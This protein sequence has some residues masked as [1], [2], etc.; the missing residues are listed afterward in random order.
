VILVDGAPLAGARL[1][2][3]RHETAWVDPAIQLWNRS[4]LENLTYGSEDL[5][6]LGQVIG[7]AELR[8]V[9]AGLPDGMQASL[10]EGGALISGGEGQRVRLG[11]AMLRARPRL[12]I[13]DEPFR[14]LDRE[15]RHALLTRARSLWSG[16]TL[17]CITHDIEETRGFER[18]LVIEGGT[19]VE[20]GSSQT[21]AE[22]EGS[23]YHA[24]LSAEVAVRE[25]IWAGSVWRRIKLEQ[26]RILADRG[27]AK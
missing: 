1:E 14:G 8:S 6:G 15:R 19:I 25:G 23:R 9:L 22:R 10:G 3:L 2:A 13:L 17:L 12:V 27:P 18:I 7:D 26:G 5:N 11:R 4:L 16:V 24:L 20:D 21:L